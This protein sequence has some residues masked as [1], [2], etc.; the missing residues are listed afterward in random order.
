M[1]PWEVDIEVLGRVCLRMIFL[2]RG[3]RIFILERASGEFHDENFV[4]ECKKYHTLAHKFKNLFLPR[5]K[6]KET[7]N[8]R[9]SFTYIIS[10]PELVPSISMSRC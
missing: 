10:V 3:D 8:N 6:D 4:P 1:V 7:V 5:P 9:G 2:T